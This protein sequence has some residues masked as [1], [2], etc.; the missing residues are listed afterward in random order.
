[1]A[2]TGFDDNER[3]KCTSTP[4]VRLKGDKKQ[5]QGK[6][7]GITV[8]LT[9]R[10]SLIQNVNG[11]RFHTEKLKSRMLYLKYA[12]HQVPETPR[13]RLSKRS[14]FWKIK[15]NKKGRAKE[16]LDLDRGEVQKHRFL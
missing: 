13:R 2:V 7:E 10:S 1:V 3:Q 8:A 6:A 4:Y 15:R 5:I 9:T 11:S 12:L 14:P 16:L